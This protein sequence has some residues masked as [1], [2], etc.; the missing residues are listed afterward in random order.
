VLLLAAFVAAWLFGL[1]A[2]RSRAAP[3]EP[4]NADAGLGLGDS[5]RQSPVLP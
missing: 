5:E 3:E 2:L 1:Q 4:D